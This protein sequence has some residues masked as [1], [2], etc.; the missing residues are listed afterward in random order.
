MGSSERRQRDARNR[1][2]AIPISFDHGEKARPCRPSPPPRSP[3]HH[4]DP[5][6]H[7]RTDMP[8]PRQ[9]GIVVRDNT[10]QTRHD[11]E[12]N[13]GHKSRSRHDPPCPTSNRDRHEASQEGNSKKANP[14]P[15]PPP[16]PPSSHHGGGGPRRSRSPSPVDK[17]KNPEPY[18]A[19]SRIDKIHES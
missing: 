14:P 1:K 19:R 17:K 13:Q 12:R 6:A 11:G 2:D 15:P 8:P 18:D 3:R 10:E 5:K 4:K 9:G 7:H 16:S